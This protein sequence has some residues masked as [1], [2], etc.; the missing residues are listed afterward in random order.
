MK[1]QT[2]LQDLNARVMELQAFKQHFPTVNLMLDGWFKS[3]RKN[4]G[5]A[6]AMLEQGTIKLLEQ[7]CERNEKEEIN[8]KGLFKFAKQVTEMGEMDMPVFIDEEHAKQYK[9]GWD[10]LM[11]TKI[12]IVI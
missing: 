2:T 5:A 8:V 4:N 6:I 3:F 1:I 11:Q 9:D 7:H 12:T 10:K